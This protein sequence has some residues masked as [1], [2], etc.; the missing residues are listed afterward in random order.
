MCLIFSY[1]S[2]FINSNLYRATSWRDDHFSQHVDNGPVVKK[3]FIE[4]LVFHTLMMDEVYVWYPDLSTAALILLLFSIIDLF[5][6]LKDFVV[7]AL[8]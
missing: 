5:S 8:E 6:K 2:F 4:S 7:L 3:G 1:D